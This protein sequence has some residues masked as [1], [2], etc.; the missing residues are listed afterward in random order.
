MSIC[1][2]SHLLWLS[3]NDG[4]WN[5]IVQRSSPHKCGQKSCCNAFN[6]VVAAF[7][8]RYFCILIIF[9]CAWSSSL[10]MDLLGGSPRLPKY[11]Y[12]FVFSLRDSTLW[13]SPNHLLLLRCIH[14]LE[15][16]PRAIIPI[17]ALTPT[18]IIFH[19]NEVKN[20]YGAIGHT[21]YIIRSTHQHYHFLLLFTKLHMRNT[22][23]IIW[24]L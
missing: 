9:T 21:T 20:R 14:V 12:P 10:F 11:P 15:Q 19:Q 17:W 4:G 16:G 6:A 23:N 18:I 2:I 5:C 3:V 13:A 8:S 22:C 1:P 7:A 24:E